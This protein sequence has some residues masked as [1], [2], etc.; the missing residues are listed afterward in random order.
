MVGRRQLFTRESGK[1][2]C[3]EPA[4]T[5][6]GE[7]FLAVGKVACFPRARAWSAGS[8]DE[9]SSGFCPRQCLA[10]DQNGVP[11]G[12][13]SIS[14]GRNELHELCICDLV[15]AEKEVVCMK[16]LAIAVEVPA[17]N[18]HHAFRQARG[19]IERKPI[20]ADEK[21]LVVDCTQLCPVDVPATQCAMQRPIAF[22]LESDLG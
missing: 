16:L 6:Y 22:E 19:L 10:I 8:I 20:Y 3:L 11:Q 9:Q 12:L 18:A 4:D 5:R 1:C 2:L 15:P 14:S 17:W 7:V 13:I 21:L